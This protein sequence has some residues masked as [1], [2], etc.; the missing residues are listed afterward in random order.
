[1]RAPSAVVTKLGL[2]PR[3]FVSVKMLPV[4]FSI[5]LLLWRLLSGG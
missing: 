4:T 3:S 2:Q 5:E 1:M